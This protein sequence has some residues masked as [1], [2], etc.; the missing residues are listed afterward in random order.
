MIDNPAIAY[1]PAQ[2]LDESINRRASWTP[3]NG[4]TDGRALVMTAT[5]ETLERALY[6]SANRLALALDPFDTTPINAPTEDESEA[7]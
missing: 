2:S 6:L 3:A 4:G 1:E 7:A 5:L